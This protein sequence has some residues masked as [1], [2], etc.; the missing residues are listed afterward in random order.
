LFF[1]GLYTKPFSEFK[2]PDK[3]RQKSSPRRDAEK[4]GFL[5]KSVTAWEC[6]KS[7]HKLLPNAKILPGKFN[8]Q[9][10]V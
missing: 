3:P 6:N 1:L 4:L 10:I 2:A 9:T 5:P 7:P 8:H